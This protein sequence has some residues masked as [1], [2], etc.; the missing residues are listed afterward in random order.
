[1]DVS[2]ANPQLQAGAHTRHSALNF[3]PGGLQTRCL[4]SQEG[5]TDG[6]QA[7]VSLSHGAALKHVQRVDMFCGTRVWGCTQHWQYSHGFVC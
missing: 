7:W 5:H 4:Q 2:R 3:P 6:Q 1:M